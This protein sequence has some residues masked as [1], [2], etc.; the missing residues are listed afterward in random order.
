[1]SATNVIYRQKTILFPEEPLHHLCLT[2]PPYQREEKEKRTYDGIS[3]R[4]AFHLASALLGEGYSE[5]DIAPTLVHF[6][7]KGRESLRYL[8]KGISSARFALHCT[9]QEHALAMWKTL[10]RLTS[11][12]R[13]WWTWELNISPLRERYDLSM[14]CDAFIEQ[15]RRRMGQFRSEMPKRYHNF[16]SAE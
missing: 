9:Q 8:L 2:E 6:I 3:P 7:Q 4:E 15:F 14:G 16:H 13:A 12:E 10:A 1:M 11:L 5:S